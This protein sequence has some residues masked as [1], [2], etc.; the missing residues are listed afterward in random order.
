VRGREEGRSGRS[1]V[2]SW[3]VKSGGGEF[4]LGG[5]GGVGEGSGC[6]CEFRGGGEEYGS[7]VIDGGGGGEVKVGEAG[8]IGGGC[9]GGR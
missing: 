6:D 5:V 3:G 8:W 2:E 4:V 7:N 1:N 9:S